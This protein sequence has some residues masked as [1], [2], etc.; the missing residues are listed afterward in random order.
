[1]SD[2]GG[3]RDNGTGSRV[4][5]CGDLV[6]GHDGVYVPSRTTGSSSTLPM[7]DAQKAAAAEREKTKQIGFPVPAVEPHVQ[8]LA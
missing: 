2:G 3:R 1:M 8:G 6:S 7:D 5:H 4:V